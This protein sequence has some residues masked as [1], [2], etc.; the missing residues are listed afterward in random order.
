MSEEI[1][2][3]TTI[4]TLRQPVTKASCCM[5]TVLVSSYP[6]LSQALA[7]VCLVTVYQYHVPWWKCTRVGGSGHVHARMRH[8]PCHAMCSD[9]MGIERLGALFFVWWLQIEIGCVGTV[10]TKLQLCVSAGQTYTLRPRFG[11]FCVVSKSCPLL[12]LYHLGICQAPNQCIVPI[13]SCI[14]PIDHASKNIL[15]YFI[16][17]CMCWVYACN[18]HLLHDMEVC[19]DL[20]FNDGVMQSRIH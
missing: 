3:R 14:Y 7:C 13:L 1:K 17:G 20:L 18:E 6:S 9:Q 16:S 19:T 15:L 10:P 5:A 4:R 12:F 2:S 11:K 8:M